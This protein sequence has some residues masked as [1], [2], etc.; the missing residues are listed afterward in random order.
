MYCTTFHSS[1]ILAFTINFYLYKITCV[2]ITVFTNKVLV[3]M[4]D[5]R[6]YLLCKD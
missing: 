6:N 3:L 1:Y 4:Q 5:K 2:E